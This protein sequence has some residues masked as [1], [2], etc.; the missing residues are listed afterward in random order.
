MKEVPPFMTEAEAD[1]VWH[2]SNDARFGVRSPTTTEL[3]Q[4]IDQL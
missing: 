4:Q 3:K 2:K 1:K